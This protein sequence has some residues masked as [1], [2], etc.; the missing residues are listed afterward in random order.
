VLV[1]G[2]VPVITAGVSPAEVI[3][4]GETRRRVFLLLMGIAFV[5]HF[6]LEWQTG[7]T[8]GKQLFGLRVVRDTGGSIGPMESFIRNALRLIDG[9]GYWSVAVVVILLRGDGKRL[10]DMFGRTRVVSNETELRT[11]SENDT[12][13]TDDCD[14]VPP[15]RTNTPVAHRHTPRVVEPSRT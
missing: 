7:T 3:S 6:L 14:S 1:L 13:H 2:V 10:G 12:F 4:P 15:Q 9:L 5:Y 11:D 8:A